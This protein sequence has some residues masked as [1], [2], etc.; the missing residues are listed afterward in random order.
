M[1]KP[2]PKLGEVFELTLNGNDPDVQPLAMVRK[3]GYKPEYWKHSGKTVTG[4][5]TRKFQLVS[6]GYCTGWYELAE[7]LATFGP[8]PEGQWLEAFKTEYGPG[9]NCHIGVADPSWVD[10]HGFA[11]F[12]CM[13]ND[14]DSN[15][16]WAD[17]DF[18]VR[19]RWLV[20]VK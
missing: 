19:W 9:G 15:F 17:S 8:T 11:V 7:K 16:D 4:Q 18:S 6:V 20:P 14:G 3:Y 10:P 13:H 12:P 1:T 5:Q 2:Y